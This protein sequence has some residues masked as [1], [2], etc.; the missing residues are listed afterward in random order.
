MNKFTRDKIFSTIFGGIFLYYAT[1]SFL[2][3]PLQSLFVSILPPINNR[4]LPFDLYLGG[5]GALTGAVL[6]FIIF[7]LTIEKKPFNS[8][9]KQYIIAVLILIMIPLI[10]MF[11]FRI[12]AVNYVTQ[13]ERTTPTDMR[14]HLRAPGTS[15][16]FNVSPNCATG[17][18]KNVGVEEDLLEE[19]G[20][21]IRDMK[22]KEVAQD[23]YIEGDCET[24]F[25][26]YQIK[27][28]WYSKIL[29]HRNGVFEERVANN[30]YAIYESKGLQELIEKSISRAGDLA[31][32][33]KGIINDYES[34]T[35]HKKG[36]ELSEQDLK[37]LIESVI[38]A[39]KIDENHEDTSGIKT[40][41]EEGISQDMNNLYAISL[42]K[43]DERNRGSGNF[44]V[45]DNINRVI[46]FEGIYY[47]VDL[48][49]IIN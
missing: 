9:K 20:Q 17:I 33:N 24:L 2:R 23:N 37:R 34:E 26:D 27:G 4:N 6:V 32:Y 12:H 29:R 16:V 19:I 28:K 11:A 46:F 7:S 38:T 15:I 42:I 25:I 18:S 30:K 13:A 14:I 31:S 1:I 48:N 39:R 44:M 21:E 40:A 49:W 36:E 47:D 3:S 5:Y 45:Y 41:L 35:S 22:L 43:R 10:M 8:Y